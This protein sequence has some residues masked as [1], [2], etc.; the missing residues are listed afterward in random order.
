[1][2]TQSVS[3]KRGLKLADKGYRLN[4]SLVTPFFYVF[5]VCPAILLFAPETWAVLKELC[6]ALMMICW[7]V[8]FAQRAPIWEQEANDV[9]LE[10]A[11]ERV[12]DGTERVVVSEPSEETN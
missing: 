1:M 2:K 3:P 12:G 11:R 4:A 5:I 6:S 10:A 7:G 9:A 8:V